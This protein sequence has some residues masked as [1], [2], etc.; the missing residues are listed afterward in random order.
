[1]L[2][3]DAPVGAILQIANSSTGPVYARKI[4]AVE[5]GSQ[6]AHNAE[7]VSQDGYTMCPCYIMDNQECEVVTLEA[8]KD[9]KYEVQFGTL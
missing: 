7:W 9:K 4:K 2:F 5:A 1:M 3:K 6:M 8:K